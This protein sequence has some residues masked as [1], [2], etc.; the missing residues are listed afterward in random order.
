[1]PS[2]RY[3]HSEFG[4]F[5]PAPR[6]RREL[7]LTCYAGL[8]GAALGAAS[9]IALSR[10]D[11]AAPA[12]PLPTAATQPGAEEA[13]P[14]QVANMERNDLH[15][16]AAP[17]PAEREAMQ[18]APT[19][20]YE[21]TGQSNA[22]SNR[23]NRGGGEAAPRP[24]AAKARSHATQ[25]DN[26]PELARIPLGRPA[27]FENAIPL[28][29][30]GDGAMTAPP[31]PAASSAMAAP[32]PPRAQGAPPEPPR[33]VP[34]DPKPHRIVRIETR[35]QKQQSEPVRASSGSGNGLGDLGRA[36][37]RDTAF[38]RTVFWDWSR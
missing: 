34:L 15:R 18:R 31:V 1:V 16:P 14:R 20:R 10:I 6:L 5:C 12:S 13:L 35:P 17:Q 4:Y 23:D 28:T 38:P 27:A 29:A 22:E 11:R 7:R 9:V 3:F 30:E 36:Y 33:A 37:A 25:R 32:A 8:F 19:R 21:I 2:D 26:G 24:Y